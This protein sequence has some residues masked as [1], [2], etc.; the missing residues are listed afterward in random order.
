MTRKVYYES[1]IGLNK[2]VKLVGNDISNVSTAIWRIAEPS[3]GLVYV[4]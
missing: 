2:Y 3:V 1:V 4:F